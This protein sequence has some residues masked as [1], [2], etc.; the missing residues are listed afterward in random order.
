MAS[1]PPRDRATELDLAR[2]AR[3]G[4]SAAFRRLVEPHRDHMWAVCISITSH[5]QDAEDALQDS[6]IA[7]WRNI[8]RFEGKSR[9]STWL[10]RIASNAA[11]MIVRK[12]RD[13][14]ESDA[15]AAEADAAPGIQ[16]RVTTVGV[17]RACLAELPPEFREA[18]VLREYADMTYTEIA[19]HQGVAVATVKTRLNRGR[20]KLKAALAGAGAV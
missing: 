15:G 10:H 12:R 3:D 7:A 14:P 16:E 1:T 18:V 6:L 9:F 19:E 4:D 13:V 8:A 11:L 2:R 20:A 17:V 5:R